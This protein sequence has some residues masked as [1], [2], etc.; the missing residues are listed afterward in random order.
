MDFNKDELELFD[1][2]SKLKPYDVMQI[3]VN[4]NGTRMSVTVKNNEQKYR[5]FKITERQFLNLT[6]S[7]E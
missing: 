4:Q 1:M 6:R 3:A 2:I 5:E 7:E